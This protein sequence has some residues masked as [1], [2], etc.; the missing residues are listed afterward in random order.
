[1]GRGGKGAGSGGHNDGCVSGVGVPNTLKIQSNNSASVRPLKRGAWKSIS[2]RIQPALQMSTYV[3]YATAD[4]LFSANSN[5]GARY[6][7]VITFAV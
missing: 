5:S 3:E 7:K 2:A 6:H 4:A 1:M